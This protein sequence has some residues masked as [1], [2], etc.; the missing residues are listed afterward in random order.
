MNYEVIGII[1]TLFVLLS[2]LTKGEAKIRLINAIG[3]IG[4]VIY[5]L[6]LGALSVWLLN[7]IVLIINTYKGIKLIKEEKKNDT[8]N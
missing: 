7:G 4:F 3:C 2:F 6:L 8:N 5:G 1:S